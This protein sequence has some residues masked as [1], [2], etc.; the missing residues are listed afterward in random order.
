MNMIEALCEIITTLFLLI[1]V[2][3]IWLGL[4]G[5]IVVENRPEIIDYIWKLLFEFKDDDFE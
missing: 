3:T 5:V 2:M 1:G 4:Y